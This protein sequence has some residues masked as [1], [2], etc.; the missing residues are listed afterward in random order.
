MR[1]EINEAKSPAEGGGR[2]AQG[3]GSRVAAR[4]QR[5]WVIAFVVILLAFMAGLLPMWRK[6]N[7][8]SSEVDI[9][10]R[11]QT[12]THLENLAGAAV[13]DSRRGEYEAARRSASAFFDKL[14]SEL[15]AGKT[16]H[17]TFTE[18]QSLRP[19][20]DERDDLITLLARS[21]PASTERLTSL[22]LGC[23]SA[24]APLQTTEVTR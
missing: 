21:D 3:L 18:Q 22:Y 2:A 8:L 4:L 5:K 12:T 10:V 17:L 16:S 6:A 7:R 24:L 14:R 13:I 9:A 11:T 15:D 1:E 19:F 20:L 23:R